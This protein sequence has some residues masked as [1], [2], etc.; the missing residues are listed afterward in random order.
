MAARRR[1]SSVRTRRS[2]VR[3]RTTKKGM[4]RRTAR[5]A[6]SGLSKKKVADLQKRNKSLRARLQKARS[7][8]PFPHG[9]HIKTEL[10]AFAFVLAGGAANGSLGAMIADAQIT[11]MIPPIPF[12]IKPAWALTGLLF[13]APALGW[14]KGANGARMALASSGMAAAQASDFFSK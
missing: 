14:G 7:G 10:E 1:R 13:A 2:P 9:P 6:F 8:N 11:G 12:G 3:R 4:P 5:R